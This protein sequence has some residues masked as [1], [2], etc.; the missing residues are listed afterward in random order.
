MDKLISVI[1][2]VYNTEKYVKE[3]MESVLSQTYTNLELIIVNDGSSD[4]SLKVIE[5]IARKDNRIVVVDIPNSGISKARNIG[6]EKAKGEYIAVM[7]SDD[8]CTPNRLHVQLAF[9][10]ENNLDFCGSYIQTI[11]EGQGSV[12]KYPVAEIDIGY[13]M[14]LDSPFAHPTVLIRREILKNYHYNINY[15]AAIDYELWCRLIADGFKCSNVKSVLLY[16]R[17]HPMQTVKRKFKDKN[18]NF[19][20]ANSGYIDSINLELPFEKEYIKQLSNRNTKFDKNS[21]HDVFEL[22]KFI[23]NKSVDKD[24]IKQYFLNFYKKHAY[25]GSTL[26]FNLVHRYGI[27]NFKVLEI[28]LLGVFTKKSS[29]YQI[30]KRIYN[31]LK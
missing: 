17:I 23:L 16:Y 29:I 19:S 31:R 28:G 18:S 30:L 26:F 22:E 13:C 12:W 10:L 3:A 6:I 27:F 21:I 14:L 5:A 2:S 20:K 1:I 24:I 9:L 8:I 25:L 7:D 4:D 15:Q 11:G